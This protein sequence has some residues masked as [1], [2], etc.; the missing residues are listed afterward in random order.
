V[1]FI[2]FV[3]EQRHIVAAFSVITSGPRKKDYGAT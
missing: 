1:L 2:S 3:F